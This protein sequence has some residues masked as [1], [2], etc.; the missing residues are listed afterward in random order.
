[1]GLWKIIFVF[2]KIIVDKPIFIM[3]NMYIHLYKQSREIELKKDKVIILRIE[4][5]LSKKA[6]CYAEKNKMSLSELIRKVLKNFLRRNKN[7]E[8][9]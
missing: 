6:F 5:E 8:K 9:I 1:M 7:N 4:D 3:Y 2:L